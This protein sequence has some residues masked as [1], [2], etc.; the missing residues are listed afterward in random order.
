MN[1]IRD[2]IIQYK[3]IKVDTEISTYD[4]LIKFS[5]KF[6]KDV[7]E[8]YDAVTRI[9]NIERNPT[10]FDFNDS[11]ILGLLIRIWKILKEV[12]HYYGKDNADI[13]SLLD[14]PIIEA[15][16]IAKYLLIKGDKAIED[17]RKCSYKDRLNIITDSTRSPDFFTTPP[18]IRLKQSIIKKMKA[19]KLTVD[20][21]GEQ[22]RN[23][24]KLSGKRFDQLFSEVEPKKFY[25]YLYG[26]PS[27]SI[28]GSWN[29]SMDFNLT[30]N[31]DGSFSPNPFYQKVDIRFVTPI[32]RL[33]HDPYLLWL[34]R[35]DAKSEYVEKTFEW[36]KSI[37]IKLFDSFEN[38]YEMR[39]G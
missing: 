33:S 27:E 31:D 14:R 32:L 15:A 11:A 37:N 35:I 16:V 12:V 19:E 22:K 39:D 8:I 29:E 10:G 13:I 24:W 23:R 2:I 1:E 9:K 25:K 17:Y 26:I 4:G 36:I 21:F 3:D 6:Y 7:A 38:V 20:S 30:R 18:G 5:T 28:H 34:N